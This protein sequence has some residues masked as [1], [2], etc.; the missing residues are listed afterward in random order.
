MPNDSGLAFVLVPHLDP[1]H[2]SLMVELLTRQTQ[3]PVHEVT[4]DMVIEKNNVYIIP[5]A[6]YLS[7]DKG[8]L[9]LSDPP[10]QSRVD[11]AIDHFLRSLAE[12]QQERA[13]GIVLSG[14]SSHGTLGLQAIKANGGVAIAQKP[15][16]AEY[17]SMPQNAIDTGIIDYILPPE[18]MPATLIKY[19]QHAYVSGAWESLEPAKT[20]LE[21][22]D[23]LLRLLKARTRYDF[24]NY[25]KNMV[26]RRVRRRMGLN[27]PTTANFC[28]M[29]PTRQKVYSA[30]C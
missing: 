2:Q 1:S 3:M 22:L 28:V 17:D 21:Q 18:E 8:K 27:W 7:V 6:K 26:M 19:A 11:T 14:T 15:D 20:E 24:R 12:S 10:P 4:D 5:P 25:R 23:R 13:I 30:T 29:I 16:T 9:R